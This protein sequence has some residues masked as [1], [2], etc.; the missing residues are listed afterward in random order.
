MAPRIHLARKSEVDLKVKA[1]ILVYSGMVITQNL[2]S[3]RSRTSKNFRAKVVDCWDR[4][5]TVGFFTARHSIFVSRQWER[6]LSRIGPQLPTRYR[7]SDKL[8]FT[9]TK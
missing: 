6:L 4:L 3:R 1:E 8:K 9:S 5:L 2:L 7:L